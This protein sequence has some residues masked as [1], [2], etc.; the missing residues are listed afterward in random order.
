[1]NDATLWE[2]LHNWGMGKASKRIAEQAAEIERLR[3]MLLTKKDMD[4]VRI[5]AVFEPPSAYRTFDK[6]K[7][8]AKEVSDA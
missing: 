8:Q 7:Q 6:L 4:S 1:M 5:M 3:G 2:Y